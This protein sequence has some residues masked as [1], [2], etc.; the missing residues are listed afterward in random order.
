MSEIQLP[1]EWIRVPSKSGIFKFKKPGDTLEGKYLK[2]ESKPFRGRPNWKYCLASDNP[3]SVDG[4]IS[5]F[6]TDVLN[7]AMDQIPEGAMVKIV[8]K[9]TKPSADPQ[10]QGLKDF[11]VFVWISRDDPLYKQL[12][13]EESED[14]EA[15]P[16]QEL[17]TQDHTKTDEL[18]ECYKDI[19]KDKTPYKK[20]T[21]EAIIK[22]AEAD[23]ELEP[24]QLTNIKL[25]LIDL[26]KKGEIES[27]K[28]KGGN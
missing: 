1:V 10:K 16:G 14:G 26:Y 15:A 17:Q 23:E 24:A 8:F 3:S 11:D 21:C 19:L 4:K 27:E 18:I 20:I 5:F 12:Y 9:K 6:G 7:G 2:R 13:P 22:E 25:R 28:Q